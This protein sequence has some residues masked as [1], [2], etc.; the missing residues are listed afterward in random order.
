M[1]SLNTSANWNI[2]PESRRRRAAEP[3]PADN[4]MVDTARHYRTVTQRTFDRF[5]DRFRTATVRDMTTPESNP[6]TASEVNEL[7]L[8]MQAV[9]EHYSMCVHSAARQLVQRVE[10]G[11]K[12]KEAE[13]EFDEM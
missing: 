3:I 11:G 1:S 10:M 5:A 4:C 7:L 9:T 6:S 2:A 13:M 8:L 12:I